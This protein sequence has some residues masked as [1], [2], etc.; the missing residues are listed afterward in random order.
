MKDFVLNMLTCMVI[1]GLMFLLVASLYAPLY[2]A[3]VALT[4][5][6]MHNITFLYLAILYG[7]SRLWEIA[8]P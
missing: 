4:G 8:K 6:S 7:V 5:T 3:T 2:V 1:F